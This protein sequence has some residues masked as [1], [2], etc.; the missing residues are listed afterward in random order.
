MVFENLGDIRNIID[1][2]Q[3]EFLFIK[4]LILIIVFILVYISL[5]RVFSTNNKGI[6]IIM[7]LAISI[8]AVFYLQEELI[9]KYILLP[10]ASLGLLFIIGLPFFILLLITHKSQMSEIGRKGLW[11][12]FGGIFLFTWY[13]NYNDLSEIENKM[14]IGVMAL[15]ALMIWADRQIHKLFIKK[16]KSN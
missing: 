4:F 10:Y 1:Y 3:D 9:S 6:N 12:I 16:Y 14:M 11:V 7:S 15:V 13:N 8:I 2:S 5:N